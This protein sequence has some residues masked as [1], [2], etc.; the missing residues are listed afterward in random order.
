MPIV[1][2]GRCEAPAAGAVRAITERFTTDDGGVETWPRAFT[3]PVKLVRVG[4]SPTRL[5]TWAPRREAAVRCM[6]PRLMACPFTKVF[7]EAAVTARASCA[8]RKLVWFTPELFKMLTLVIRVF[9]MFTLLM[10]VR[11]Q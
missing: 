11:L 2:T 5:L 9:L 1:R 10:N 7:R 3:A 6:E 8:K 4:V